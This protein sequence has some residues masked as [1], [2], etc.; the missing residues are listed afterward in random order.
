MRIGVLTTSLGYHVN[1]LRR[2]AALRGHDVDIMQWTDLRDDVAGGPPNLD[3]LLLR[4]MGKSSLEQIIFRMDCLGRWAKRGL[5]IVNQPRTI[6]IAA[7]K[8][9]ALARL[10]DCGLPVPRTL[11]CQSRDHAIAAIDDLGGDVVLKPLFGA[12]GHGLMRIA[13]AADLPEPRG[14]VYYLQQFID[15]GNADLRLMVIAGRVIAAMRRV[16]RDWRTNIAQGGR[17][18]PITP[19]EAL[20]KLAVRAAAACDADIAGVDIVIDRAGDP[21]L[22]EVNACPGWEALAAVTGI[23]IADNVIAHLVCESWTQPAGAR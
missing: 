18:E 6:E 16:G 4:P 12:Q 15:H 17:G 21:Y 9:L 13:T 8:Y 1:D 23:D 22:L 14:G 11:V 7:D 10:A 20:C 19:D 2:A 3:A 5:R